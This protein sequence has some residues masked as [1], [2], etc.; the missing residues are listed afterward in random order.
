MT[1]SHRSK[2]QS[3]LGENSDEVLSGL[4]VAVIGAS[5]GGSHIAQ[6]LAHV[7]FGNVHLI[8]PDFAE[9]HHRHR[10]IGITT[11]AIKHSWPKVNVLRRLMRRVHPEG[12]VTTHAKRWQEVHEV[13]RTQDL[14]FTCIDGYL[15]R[16]K[17]ER[18]LRRY[19]VPMVDIGMDV[20][21]A[22]TGY[23]I[24]GQIILSM[25]GR[26]C[27]R[28]FGFIRDE[29]LNQ[30]AARYGDSGA[31]PQVVWSSGFLAS[32]AVGIA[33][34]LFLPWQGQPE[35][36]CP[37]LV[38]DGNAFTLTPSPR[39]M[40]LSGLQCQHFGATAIPG[41]LTGSTP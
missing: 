22:S 5:G 37:Y 11:A 31:F 6:Q 24:R 2:R 34:S 39:L 20:V 26:H 35:P 29:L 19:L 16:E 36:P 9:E 25:P 38:Y 33:T 30:E 17:I 23:Q 32:N 15:A 28:C 18:Y 1:I 21:K 8:D 12:Q 14:V 4:S 41:D 3:F 27:M 40:Y 13:L 10:L 7:G